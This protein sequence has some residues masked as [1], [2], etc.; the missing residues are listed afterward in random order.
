MA[1]HQSPGK[2][3][4]EGITLMQ[5]FEMFPDEAT[6]TA[7]FEQAVWQGDRCCG[8]CGSLSTRPVPHAKPMPYWCPN[9]RSYFSVRTG[10]PMARSNVSLR[11]WVIAIYLCVTSLKSVSSMKLHR[12]IGVSQSAAWFMLHRIRQAWSAQPTRFT[13]PVEADETFVGG[14]AKSMHVDRRN[15]MRATGFQKTI[16]AGVKDR[17]TNHVRANVVENSNAETLLAYVDRHTQSDTMI[18]TDDFAGYPLHLL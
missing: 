7:W 18:Y 14:K 1:S 2:A 9:C 4:R 11:K 16:V 8:K 5:L 6:A 3:H 10:T 15:T 12:D 17:H 13:G